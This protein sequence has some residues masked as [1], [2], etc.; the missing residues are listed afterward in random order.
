MNQNDRT[1][2]AVDIA[3]SELVTFD[4]NRISEI[5]NKPE[6]FGSL[7][8]GIIDPKAVLVVCEATGSYERP[9]VRWLQDRGIAV[10]VANPSRVRS[11]AKGKGVQL[12]NDR[13]DARVLHAYGVENKL[14]PTRTPSASEREVAALLDRRCHLSR[15]LTREKNRKEKQP[16]HTAELIEK[17]IE[18]IKNQI[19]EI[20]RR[21]E[22]L[23]DR[24]G[25]MR[26]DRD[27]LSSIIGVGNL[28]AVTVLTYM[29]EITEV[30][31]NV[32]VALAGLAPYDRDTGTLKGRR[33]IHGGRAKIRRCLYMAAVSAARYNPVIRDYVAGL[34]ARGKPFKCAIVAAMRKLI[35]HMQSL[36]KAHRLDREEN[37]ENRPVSA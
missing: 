36:L 4:G 6:D 20:D 32:A 27:V 13:V 16:E 3:K 22:E 9:L 34:T 21:V 33:F 19:K 2:L 29:P 23:S 17:S 37:L 1:I 26:D 18:F 12:K 25:L 35:I 15:E 5:A 28:T 10:H 14:L 7:F 11:F 8:E 31:R 30:S 24:D